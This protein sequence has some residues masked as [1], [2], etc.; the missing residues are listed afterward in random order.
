LTDCRLRILAELIGK[1]LEEFFIWYAA[2]YRPEL[3]K[4][5]V[6]KYVETLREQK[7]SSSTI[8]QKLSA[9]RRLATEAEDNNLIDSKIANSIRAVKGV[10]LKRGF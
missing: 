8:N 6:Q 10:P 3:N 7:L 9:V 5:L 2:E 1:H 4:T